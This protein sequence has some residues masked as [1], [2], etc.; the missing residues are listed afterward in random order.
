VVDPVP[1]NGRNVVFVYLHEENFDE[2]R[3]HEGSI[4]GVLE[5]VICP[6]RI[7]ERTRSGLEDH[8]TL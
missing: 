5:V 7:Q 3:F 2:K 6:L 4:R 8:L 1:C